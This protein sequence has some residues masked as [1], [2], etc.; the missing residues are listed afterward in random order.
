MLP[1]LFLYVGEHR[2]FTVRCPAIG[3]SVHAKVDGLNEV[4]IPKLSPRASDLTIRNAIPTDYLFSITRQGIRDLLRYN[5]PLY[6][7]PLS[8]APIPTVK[9]AEMF[10]V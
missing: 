10:C 4:S 7:Q 2:C 5:S 6:S 9:S 8:M 1:G 3:V